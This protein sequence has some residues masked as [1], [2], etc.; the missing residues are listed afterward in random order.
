M[1]T[2][3][4]ALELGGTEGLDAP[5]VLKSKDCNCLLEQK[6]SPF[7]LMAKSDTNRDLQKGLRWQNL[8]TVLA[9]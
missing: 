8:L 7:C 4:A 3:E 1:N 9:L 5:G 2:P 6:P